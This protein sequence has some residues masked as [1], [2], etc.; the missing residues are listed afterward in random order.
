MQSYSSRL[1]FTLVL[2]VLLISCAAPTREQRL[3]IPSAEPSSSTSPSP[4][5]SRP[6][7]T[8]S[9]PSTAAIDFTGLNLQ[10]II[11]QTQPH[12]NR[13]D[14]LY[15]TTKTQI[16]HLSVVSNC[17]V[18]ILKGFVAAG[19]A[20]IVLLQYG[21]ERQRRLWTMVE[22]DEEAEQ[23]WLVDPATRETRYMPYADFGRKW[24][25]ASARKCVL[26]LPGKL[27]EAKLHSVLAKYLSSTHIS[28]VKVRS[29]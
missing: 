24:A 7:A 1:R 11:F 16:R 14:D 23:I 27:T 18:D 8:A 26:A 29:R 3:P 6:S 28:Q 4:L 9:L 19:W 10:R 5:T 22:Y 12:I 17:D 13:I 15:G 2:C 21:N 25:V 20:P